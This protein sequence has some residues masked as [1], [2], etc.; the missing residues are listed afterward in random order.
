MATRAGKD[1][2]IIMIGGYDLRPTTKEIKTLKR[3]KVI[4]DITV[5]GVADQLPASVGLHNAQLS[6]GGYYNDQ[7]LSSNDAFR[8]QYETEADVPGIIG[9]SGIALG[10]PVILF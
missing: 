7:A 6:I 10:A 1:T 2:A 8:A 5:F 3:G 9:I 4:E